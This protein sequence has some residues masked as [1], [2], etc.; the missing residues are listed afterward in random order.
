MVFWNRRKFMAG[1]AGLAGAALIAPYGAR[2]QS[3]RNLTPGAPFDPRPAMN[4]AYADAGRPITDETVNST[5][6]NFYEFAS[7]KQISEAAQRLETD[8]WTVQFDGLVEKPF[9]IGMEDLLS[10]VALEERVIRH[11]C[12]EAWSMVAPWI[13]FPVSEAMRLAQPLSS[14]KYVRFETFY[15]PSVAPGQRE[16]W[17][18][19]PYVEGLTMAEAAHEL[20]FLVVG[21]YGKVLPKQFGAPI[22]LHVPWKYDFK[23]IKS[24]VKISFVEERPVSFWED[25][26]SSEYG[27][28]ANV[29]PS[30]AHPRWSQAT[31]R[32]LGTNERI[33]TQLFNGYAEEVCPSLC[34]LPGEVRRSPLAVTFVTQRAKKGR[35][36]RPGKVRQGGNDN[37]ARSPK[38][39][40]SADV[41]MI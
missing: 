20:S 23:S 12:V 34:W 16:P 10:K 30:I 26:A 19:W 17:Y 29:N 37:G 40:H 24:V 41:Q 11:R 9:E 22:R 21:A 15:N 1:A 33:P 13:G 18:D 2:A 3:G 38:G 39:R 28:W 5:Y 35:A 25:A 4:A 32:V 7:H 6:N 31:E 36:R 27:F 14:A 8:G